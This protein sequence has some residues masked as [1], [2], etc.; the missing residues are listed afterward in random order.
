MA[1]RPTPGTHSHPHSYHGRT[2]VVA[3]PPTT[4]CHT[5]PPDEA[6][7]A[8]MRSLSSKERVRRLSQAV[9]EGAVEDVRVL[10]AADPQMGES[11]KHREMALRRAAGKGHVEMV[12]CLLESGVD[13]HARSN[14]HTTPMHR[15]AFNDHA[16]VVRLLASYAADPNAM[17]KT[18]RTPLHCT[19]QKGCTEAAVAL[20]EVGAH[21]SARDHEGYT[22]FDIARECNNEQIIHILSRSLVSSRQS[23][24]KDHHTTHCTATLFSTC[25]CQLRSHCLRGQPS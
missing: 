24:C 6:A 7:I 15:A 21:R 17:S 10:L 22:P 16:A 2:P 14:K 1:G 13:V 3:A 5:T 23:A 25:R 12:R 11:D 4:P 19:A 9:T 8:R 18:G 20:L